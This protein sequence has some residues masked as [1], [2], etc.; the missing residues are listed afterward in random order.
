MTLCLSVVFLL[1]TTYSNFCSCAEQT[2]CPEGFISFPNGLSCIKAINTSSLSYNE[3]VEYANKRSLSLVTVRNALQHRIVNLYTLMSSHTPFWIESDCGEE[4]TGN[5]CRSMEM[6]VISNRSCSDSLHFVVMKICPIVPPFAMISKRQYIAL[7]QEYNLTVPDNIILNNTDNS[8]SINWLF[9]GEILQDSS[10]TLQPGYHLYFDSF[11][12]NHSGVYALVQ[13]NLRQS[14]IIFIMELVEATLNEFTVTPANVTIP[15]GQIAVLECESG[16]SFPPPAIEWMYID[17]MNRITNI[18]TLNNTRYYVSPV[19]SLY[20]RETKVI[21]SGVYVCTASNIAGSMSATGYLKVTNESLLN[22]PLVAVSQNPRN[23]TVYVGEKYTIE[24]CAMFSMPQSVI[25]TEL[26]SA[27][28]I[29]FREVRQPGQGR[30]RSSLYYYS[31]ME[32][33]F[34]IMQFEA[35]E[36]GEDRFSCHVTANLYTLNSIQVAI[37]TTATITINVKA[38]VKDINTSTND[39]L[40][41]IGTTVTLYCDYT[42]PS[43]NW[44]YNSLPY[45]TNVSNPTNGR[46]ELTLNNFKLSNTGTYQCIASNDYQTMIRSI[47]LSAKDGVPGI[48]YYNAT[49]ISYSSILIIWSPPQVLNT[50]YPTLLGYEIRYRK[51]EPFQPLENFQ[52]VTSIFDTRYTL[53]SLQAGMLYQIN[54]IAMTTTSYGPDHIKLVSIQPEP[55]RSSSTT[56]ITPTSSSISRSSV[57]ITTSSVRTVL[58]SVTPTFTIAPSVGGLNP[59]K[60]PLSTVILTVVLSLLILIISVIVLVCVFHRCWWN[61]RG[62][63]GNY[64]PEKVE[65]VHQRNI[66]LNFEPKLIQPAQAFDS[67]TDLESES[68]GTTL[69][70]VRVD[71][72]YHSQENVIYDSLESLKLQSENV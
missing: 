36:E 37:S 64:S 57:P 54:V 14:V 49:V 42:G 53:S 34:P 2:F 10:I 5:D 13:S 18:S 52:V 21:D 40:I 4:C 19:H 59:S 16:D 22:A 28:L 62:W 29:N 25:A 45:T 17:S 46:S 26:T 56:L 31:L 20:I 30:G 70:V 61:Y 41:S 72:I 33:T 60:T 43:V 66:M 11:L 35:E 9:N 51:L 8:T 15:T 27:L 24:C 38:S 44:Y 58:T 50:L 23:Q 1:L 55:V 12:S 69:D 7:S 67:A 68:S 3:A 65:E 39:T 6:G 48:V 63:K 32:R 71:K 47:T